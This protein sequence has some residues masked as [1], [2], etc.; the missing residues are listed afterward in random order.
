MKKSEIRTFGW[1]N[2]GVFVE[3]KLRI[4]SAWCAFDLINIVWIH[5]ASL[6]RKI[7]W[8]AQLGVSWVVFFGALIH[9]SS[10]SSLQVKKVISF[11]AFCAVTDSNRTLCA[12]LS[13]FLDFLVD[14]KV[15]FGDLGGHEA[16][17]WLWITLR[18]RC[19][20]IIACSFITICAKRLRGARNAAFNWNW[21]L[22][23]RFGYRVRKV[24]LRAVS[25]EITFIIE[26]IKL[27][28]GL[29][30]YPLAW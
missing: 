6:T 18:N 10:Y 20:I 21:T 19:E 27:Q 3:V 4:E 15:P 24:S 23:A 29:V 5:L 2:T 12:E 11:N 25:C 30:I 7:T 22:G 9:A 13:A 26:L 14:Q 17:W 8:S 28:I 1:L 16:S